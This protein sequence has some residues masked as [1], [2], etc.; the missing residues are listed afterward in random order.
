VQQTA[1]EF[2]ALPAFQLIKT[3]FKAFFTLQTPSNHQA[4]DH[5]S[6]WSAVRRTPDNRDFLLFDERIAFSMQA[7][8][9]HKSDRLLGS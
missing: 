7:Q 2:V 4:A 9:I 6:D 1:R 3:P 5:R 8:K